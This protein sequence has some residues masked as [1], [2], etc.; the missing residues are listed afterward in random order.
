MAIFR[1]SGKTPESRDLFTIFEMS[2][3][4][5]AKVSLRKG[6]GI[7]SSEQEEEVICVMVLCSS[8]SLTAEKETRLPLG[9]TVLPQMAPYMVSLV[10]IFFVMSARIL[11]ILLL[12]NKANSSHLSLD[13]GSDCL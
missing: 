4:T 5:D 3:I 11:D 8:L 13:A 7:M 10:V 6:V 12:K 1:T 9:L 2:P